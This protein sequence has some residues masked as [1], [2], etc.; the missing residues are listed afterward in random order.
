MA[1]RAGSA[2]PGGSPSRTAARTGTPSRCRLVVLDETIKVWKSAVQ[3]AKLGRDESLA[4]CGGSTARPARSS[5]T[6]PVPRST[7]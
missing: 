4:R 6:R 5:A 1:P 7:T 2:I 3:K